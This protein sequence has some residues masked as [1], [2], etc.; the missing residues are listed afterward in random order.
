MA[1]NTNTQTIMPAFFSKKFIEGTGINDVVNAKGTIKYE[2]G[3]ITVDAPSQIAV[4]S[5]D[6]KCVATANGESVAT[7][8]LSQGAYV[9]K[10]V[11]AN[12]NV[13]TMKFVK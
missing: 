1:G 6:G 11:D 13:Q 9:V 8:A 10:A 2:G 4:Y 12:G 7:D 3:I 5:I